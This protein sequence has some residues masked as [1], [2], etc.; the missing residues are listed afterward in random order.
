[1]SRASFRTVRLGLDRTHRAAAGHTHTSAGC[2]RY[3]VHVD[4]VVVGSVES[5]MVVLSSTHGP[6]R[7]MWVAKTRDG[8]IIRSRC[9]TR[10]VAVDVVLDRMTTGPSGG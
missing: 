6:T 1:M 4:G 3:L 8:A 10:N 5:V 2:R 9:K 7:K